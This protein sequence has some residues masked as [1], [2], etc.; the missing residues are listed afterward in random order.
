M[1]TFQIKWWIDGI[2]FK[3]SKRLTASGYQSNHYIHLRY[4]V[5]ADTIWQM[6]CTRTVVKLISKITNHQVWKRLFHITIAFQEHLPSVT[7]TSLWHLRHSIKNRFYAFLLSGWKLVIPPECIS[8]LAVVPVWLRFLLLL[9]HYI[10]VINLWIE[11]RQKAPQ[12]KIK[13]Y[14]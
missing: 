2:I 11:R 10:D 5:K 14:Y 3:L 7:P 13:V 4:T 8:Y 12:W 9:Y 1:N 6:T